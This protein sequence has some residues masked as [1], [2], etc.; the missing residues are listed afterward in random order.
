[1]NSS[2]IL[3]VEDEPI[4]AMDIE[5]RLVAM[6]YQPGGQAADREQALAITAAD[7]PDLVLMDIRLRGGTDGITLAE[8]LRRRLHIPV[9][10]LT[11]FSEEETLQ[12]AKLAEPE[13]FLLKPFDD[14]E[15]KSTIEIALYKHRAN[16]EI[17]RLNR[18]FDV[19]SQ[20]N[21]AVVRCSS[22]EDL[23]DR[24]C[25][26]L[27]ER[28]EIDFA[29]MGELDRA[30][31]RIH[32]V[33]C[34]G[35][36]NG[37]LA[38][39]EYRFDGSPGRLETLANPGRA[40]LSQAPAI[41]NDCGREQ[42]LFPVEKAPSSFGF[43][44]CGSFPLRFQGAVTGTL[45]ICVR[46][47]GFFQERETELL[48]EVA[49][50]VSFALDKLESTAQ[51]E[52]LRDELQR[53]TMFLQTL[54]DAMPFPVYYKDAGFR[55]LGC[56]PAMEQLLGV[57][58]KEL[59]GQSARD[60]WP[61]DLADAY[62]RADRELL[63]RGGPQ[64][65]EGRLRS[66][67][68]NEYDVIFHKAIFQNPDGSVAGIVGAVEDISE[69][70]R[71]EAELRVSEERH[72]AIVEDQTELITR[73]LPD[74][75][76][77]FVNEPYC[78][79]FGE[80]RE[81]LIGKD[82]WHHLPE[83]RRT[84][85]TKFL[86]SLTPEAPVGT[87]EHSVILP[88]GETC[89]LQ[90][91]DRAIYN[92][93]GQ[94]IEYQAVG[95]D[96]TERK[97]LEDQRSRVEAQLRQAQKMEALGTLAGGISHDF[98]NILGI[99]MGYTEIISSDLGDSS[100]LQAEVQQVL[101]A[102]RRARD[103]VQQILAFSRQK[104]QD[105]KPVQVGLIVKEALKMLRASLPSTIEIKRNLS[106]KAVVLADPTQI[107]QVLMNLC[108]NAAHAMREKGG[109]LEVT[110]EEIELRQEA[111]EPH[112]GLK[113]GPYVKL[114]VR[115]TGHGIPPGILERIFDPFFTTKEKGAGT[116]LGL[117]VVHGIVKSLDGAIEVESV[118]EQG[119][120]FEVLL[121]TIAGSAP[122]ETEDSPSLPRGTEQI[123]VVDDEPLLA[124][125]LKQMLERLGYAVECRSN[126]IEALEAFR[127]RR[128]TKRFELVVTD[129]TMPYMTGVE[130][131][132]EL[133]KL[134]PDIPI[135]LCTG[136]SEKMDA[137]M[138]KSF[139]IRGF[140]M[141]PIPQKELASMVREVLDRKKS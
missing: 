134:E 131:A 60:I 106:T 56:N 7:R 79:F 42:C 38:Q 93:Q 75:T 12:R 72:R 32:P 54:M 121:P 46:E 114:S 94:V 99:I 18:L 136:F 110:L 21:Q 81:Q 78:R 104:E 71:A 26:L 66:M 30:S 41:C 127:H 116:G 11:A 112:P 129:L 25:R 132:E 6:G 89:W 100:P 29:W 68:G 137:L 124:Q 59:V 1:M 88:D 69:R 64:I 14:R 92:A 37:L 8:E 20:V 58:C 108:T 77:V 9:I 33:A 130:L 35:Q 52:R 36:D 24:V 86:E 74:H 128:E 27:V 65:Y 102:A 50:D 138:A 63:A 95:R 126:G 48:Q 118:M 113:P 96:I 123:L 125:A 87:I 23:L 73:F 45:N 3:V 53:Q 16:R 10:F 115:D 133:M 111:T 2:R 141:K 117:A 17:Q 84:G 139:G 107:H 13:G 67:T 76:L 61:P 31:S 40:I 85:L 22:R 28:G 122:L 4:V 70:K 34:H 119:T 47:P 43:H 140:L 135:L 82:F 98:N 49:E 39:V 91:T 101:R 80:Q 83:H 5:E 51:A 57:R 109:L 105:K 97:R 62:E 120:T 44:S 15:L 90:W 19:L 103:L 55:Y